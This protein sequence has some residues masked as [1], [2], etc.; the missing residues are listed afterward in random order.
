MNMPCQFSFFMQ[1]KHS[2]GMISWAKINTELVSFSSWSQTKAP[3]AHE[4]LE[5]EEQVHF[6]VKMWKIDRDGLRLWCTH[7]AVQ[8]IFSAHIY[9]IFVNVVSETA[10]LSRWN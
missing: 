7:H 3:G 1:S 4:S 5:T 9:N 2:L 10:V 6:Y 8:S